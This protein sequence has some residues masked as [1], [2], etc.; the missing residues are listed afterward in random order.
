[1]STPMEYECVNT[2]SIQSRCRQQRRFRKLQA[3]ETMLH[4]CDEAMTLH[5]A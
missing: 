3:P 5:Q 2:Y 1:M 4:M